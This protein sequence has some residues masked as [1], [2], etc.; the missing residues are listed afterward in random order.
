MRDERFTRFEAPHPGAQLKPDDVLQVQSVARSIALGPAEPARLKDPW[1]DCDDLRQKGWDV[2]HDTFSA[3]V[4]ED[5]GRVA[6]WSKAL[7]A[8]VLERTYDFAS[9]A[10]PRDEEQALRQA[11]ESWRLEREPWTVWDHPSEHLH[12]W[13]DGSLSFANWL[14]WLSPRVALRVM[15]RLP[16][17]AMMGTSLRFGRDVVKDRDIILELLEASPIAFESDGEWKPERSVAVLVVAMAVVDYAD[18][19]HGVVERA[20]RGG[21]HRA[22]D[23]DTDFQAELSALENSELP[24]WFADAF[25]RLV[26]RPDG[27]TVGVGLLAHLA[28]GSLLGVGRQPDEWS[29]TEEACRA[30]AV[31]LGLVGCSVGDLQAMWR[32]SESLAVQVAQT[33][34]PYPAIGLKTTRKSDRTGEGARLLHAEG[35]P[36]LFAAATVLVNGSPTQDDMKNLWAWLEE[37]LIGRDPGLVLLLHGTSM[38]R[39]PQ[40]LGVLVSRLSDPAGAVKA[41]YRTLESQRRRSQFRNRYDD[42]HDVDLPSVLVLRIGLYA[43]AHMRSRPTEIAHPMDATELFFELYEAARRLWL[44]AVQD[45]DH[46]AKKLVHTCFAFVPATFPEELDSALRRMVPPLAND[47]GMVCEAALALARNQVELERVKSAFGAS[48]AD[49]SAALAEVRQWAELTGRNDDLPGDLGLL[50]PLSGPPG[51]KERRSD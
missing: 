39:V 20:S 29:V 13:R 7:E 4:R 35:L 32:R 11:A 43:A 42:D 51:N 46:R 23:A 48:G 18:A 45:F 9:L 27:R 30:L 40:I 1:S 33:P 37:L 8:E 49:V 34:R 19:I 44:T 31:Q 22:E 12:Y 15:D 2:F 24:G 28:R 25:G 41:L 21:G 47:P 36:S 3:A 6:E 50:D 14:V 17:P 26:R 10:M 38:N 16:F 5:A